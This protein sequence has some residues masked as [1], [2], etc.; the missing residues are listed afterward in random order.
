MA[1]SYTSRNRLVVQTDGGNDSTWGAKIN[2]ETAVIDEALDGV[3]S[4]SVASGNVTLSTAN[5]S[6]DQSRHRTLVFTGSPGTTRTVTPPDVE[7]NYLINNQSDSTV[8]FGNLGGTNVTI[9]TGCTAIV[10]TDGATNAVA[11]LILSSQVAALLDDTTLGAFRTSAGLEIGADVQAHGDDLDAIEALSST[12]IAVRT[13]SNTWA[14]RT[15]TGTSN[16]VTVTNG[17]GVSGNPTLSLPQSIH[18]AAD[19][20]FGS[21]TLGNAGL[22]LLDT[23]ASHDLIIAPG[24]NLSADRTLTIT[25]GDADRALTIGASAS[26]S[27][28]NTGDQTISLSGDASG[29]GTGSITVTIASGAVSLSKMANLAASRFIGRVTGSTGV[30]EAM[31]GTQATTLLDTFT[32]S[33]K[34]LVP[35][36]GSASGLFLRD[37]GSWAA[38]SGGSGSVTSVATGT[39]LTG[40]PITST[41]TISL[42]SVSNSTLMGNVSGGSAA[43]T[44]LSA[45]QV[46]TLLGYASS[47]ANTDLTS[48]AL[49]NSGLK[50][51]DTGG[52][53]TLTLKPG[54]NLTG[55]RTVT[56]NVSDAD[57]TWNFAGS[58]TISGSNTG[59]QTI[60]LTGDVTGS[61]TGSFAATI[62]NGVVTFAKMQNVATASILGRTTAGTGAIEA[63]TATQ[64]RSV[65]GIGTAG[66]QNTGTSGANV[67]LLNGVNTWSGAQALPVGSTYNSLRLAHVASGSGTATGKISWGTSAPGTLAEGEIYLRYAS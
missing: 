6:T 67:P 52:D 42:A 33:L 55:N 65:M 8:T 4:I 49:S 1:D 50:V 32:T 35:A 45:A 31:T 53:H 54:E 19:V 9:P 46:K 14:Q 39:G 7:K 40:G 20:Q 2:S 34:G 59:D 28:S 17:D 48:V 66:Q 18:T 27:G 10:Y 12:G 26:V 36:P 22:H 62:A 47:G 13:A 37:D 5:N 16:Q 63:L 15:I 61:G 43:P 23:D 21:L 64:A 60:S 56:I 58:I 3:A 25:T 44:A 51:Y 29:S 11:I 24:S 57:A 41:G 38:A 30:P